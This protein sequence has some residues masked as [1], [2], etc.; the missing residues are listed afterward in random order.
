MEQIGLKWARLSCS[1]GQ[2]AILDRVIYFSWT[3]CGDA[4][5]TDE[6]TEPMRPDASVRSGLAEVHRVETYMM[7][8]RSRTRENNSIT[9]LKKGGQEK[10][11]QAT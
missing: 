5:L 11:T 2:V 6:A 7:K 1:V 3:H 10:R 8:Q 4:M 9:E